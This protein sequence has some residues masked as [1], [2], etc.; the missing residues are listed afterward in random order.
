[1]T[2]GSPDVWLFV[3]S[4][5]RLGTPE[6]VWHCSPPARATTTTRVPGVVTEKLADTELAAGAPF[7]FEVAVYVE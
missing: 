6:S 3:A 5:D 2:T 1:M 7:A 4:I